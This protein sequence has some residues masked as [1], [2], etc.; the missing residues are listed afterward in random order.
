MGRRLAATGVAVVLAATGG[1]TGWW[2]NQRGHGR[3]SSAPTVPVF[4]AIVVRAD[5]AT[6]T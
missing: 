4:T 1:G 6:T 3:S 2:L 5:L